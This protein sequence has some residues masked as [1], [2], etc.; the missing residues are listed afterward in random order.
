MSGGG[1][2]GSLGDLGHA[3]SQGV[4][5]IGNY[6]GFDNDGKWTNSGGVFH[7]IDEGTGE[8]TGRNQSRAALNN[9]KDQQTQ[10]QT[11][12]NTLIN[13][14]NWDRQQGDMSA[15]TNAAAATS[16][17]RS[18]PSSGVNYTNSTPLG[19][20]SSGNPAGKDFLGL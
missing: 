12:A 18:N 3:I 19:W 15:S 6:Y 16:R 5:S 8:L 7:A 11:D 9:A 20:G 1:G 14:Q 17:A 4:Q 2:G 13:Q 10:A